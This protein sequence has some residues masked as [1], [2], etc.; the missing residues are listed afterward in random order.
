MASLL[1]V[2]DALDLGGVDAYQILNQALD[3]ATRKPLAWFQKTDHSAFAPS[4]AGNRT[5]MFDVSQREKVNASGAARKRNNTV[6]RYFCEGYIAACVVRSGPQ[7]K[8]D[9]A[10]VL[11]AISRD[12]LDGYAKLLGKAQT[13]IETMKTKQSIEKMREEA[14]AA[15][16][17]ADKLFGA[18]L[19]RL[20]NGETGSTDL[21]KDVLGVFQTY[22]SI[23][24]ALVAFGKAPFQLQPDAKGSYEWWQKQSNRTRAYRRDI[25]GK[26]AAVR[27]MQMGASA[28]GT[29]VPNFLKYC[30]LVA[31]GCGATDADL[32]RLYAK[33][34]SAKPDVLRDLEHE[35]AVNSLEFAAIKARECILAGG[36]VVGI[37]DNATTTDKTSLQGV[38]VATSHQAHFTIQMLYF[39]D[40]MS[41]FPGADH[42]KP[43]VVCVTKK[44]PYFGQTFPFPLER[45]TRSC[46]ALDI[47]LPS[48]ENPVMR[49]PTTAAQKKSQGPDTFTL[50]C[51]GADGDKYDLEFKTLTTMSD[52]MLAVP[53]LAEPSDDVAF[54]LNL[55]RAELDP[56]NIVRFED[57]NRRASTRDF[58]R[59]AMFYGLA[60]EV[61]FL[62]HAK[63][64]AAIAPWAAPDDDE[65]GSKGP[66]GV[67]L[68]D[69][70]SLDTFYAYSI[71]EVNP[72]YDKA[73]PR[74]V[75]PA[76]QYSVRA[77]VEEVFQ[78]AFDG[79]HLPQKRVPSTNVHRRHRDLVAIVGLGPISR[80]HMVTVAFIRAGTH[81]RRHGPHPRRTAPHHDA[82]PR[83]RGRHRRQSALRARSAHRGASSTP[84]RSRRS[85]G[86]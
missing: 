36:S 86:P 48:C 30:G 17:E 56:T 12:I 76:S 54:W 73:T 60:G 85:R 70:S 39:C 2:A 11:A 18:E 66:R 62:Y 50:A 21:L 72:F 7:R 31:K 82:P 79:V 8:Q 78:R 51:V 64:L 3:E 34:E 29:A 25:Q 71:Q 53:E 83:R 26:L 16:S 80:P 13:S 46:S 77:G 52:L 40:T 81:Y 75:L 15:W 28:N 33:R 23:R 84:Q 22:P 61:S 4:E 74:C 5:F 58:A 10:P 57:S 35:F 68:S 9:A 43:E 65:D 19:G 42:K 45:G 49:P 63:C 47:E 32:R 14:N 38:D 69:H 59:A 41:R 37:C 6:V 67:S 20:L 27:F 24:N 1:D 55:C 44:W